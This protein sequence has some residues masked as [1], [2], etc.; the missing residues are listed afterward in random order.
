M[1]SH[2]HTYLPISPS[3]PDVRHMLRLTLV[4]ETGHIESIF[5]E[6]LEESKHTIACVRTVA[7]VHCMPGAAGPRAAHRLFLSDLHIRNT[8]VSHLAPN[9]VFFCSVVFSGSD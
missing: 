9:S 5:K 8:R 3:S 2:T 4:Q 7:A 6:D 1:Y